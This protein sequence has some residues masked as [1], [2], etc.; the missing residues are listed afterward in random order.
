MLGDKILIKSIRIRNLLSFGSDTDETEL[1]S[2]NVLVGPNASGKSNLIET[3]GLLQAAPKDLTSPFRGK[4][5]GGFQE[6]LWKG[7]HTPPPKEIDVSGEIE[8]TVNYDASREK[9]PLRYKISL[10]ISGQKYMVASEVV[11][12]AFPEY[13]NLKDV[14]FYYR[15]SNGHPIL[16]IPDE[17]GV[18]GGRTSKQKRKLKH[19]NPT[20]ISNDQSI[21]SH[22]KDPVQYPEITY[23]GKQFEQIKLYREWNLGR[24]T[25]PRRPQPTDMPD[26]FLEEDAN[27][28][29]LVLNSLQHTPPVR[30]LILEHMANFSDSFDNLNFKVQGGTVQLFLE[31][32]F[33]EEGSGSGLIPATRL[34]DGTL[35]F[36][37]LL[38]VLCHPTPPPLICIE[39]PEIGLHPDIIPTVA[40]LLIEASHRTQLIVTTHSDILIDALTHVPEALVLCEKHNGKTSMRRE[41]PEKLKAWLKDHRLGQLWLRGDLGGTRW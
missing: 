36:L 20:D 28:L 18:S 3:I 24:N 22:R 15:L 6:W 5:G 33:S 4:G 14:R 25:A 17:N 23:L 29:V 12:N 39:E 16:N 1:L 13:R 2:L 10:A 41:E 19:L 37:C 34:S 40:Q 21:L 38:S 32:V 11:E 30:D 8:V 26:D 31:E 35:R 27:N 9:V 7:S